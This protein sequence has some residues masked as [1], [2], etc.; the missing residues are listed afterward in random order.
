MPVGRE[1]SLR[2]LARLNWT[3]HGLLALGLVAPCMTV[4]PRM[5]PQTGVAKWLGL[6]GDPETYSILSGVV[7]FLQG[8]VP[9]GALLLVFSVLF[10]VTKLIVFR[11]AIADA[12]SGN[13]IA[14]ALR[15]VTTLGKFSMVDV[16]VIALLV[17]ASRS[18]PGGTSV[19]LLWGAYAFAAAALLSIV[20]GIGLTRLSK[21]P[22]VTHHLPVPAPAEDRAAMAVGP[23]DRRDPPSPVSGPAGPV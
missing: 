2:T 23:E 5:G 17:V 11:M 6:V 7:E 18:F 22:A 10:P 4:T 8:N 12:R 13:P 9:I 15:V 16:F 21:R 20:V 3:G 19:D 1:P 14:P